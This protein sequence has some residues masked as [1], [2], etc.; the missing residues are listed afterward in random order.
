[1]IRYRRGDL[2]ADDSEAFV[3]AVNC[4]GVM[5]GGIARQF[6]TR[7]P[8][9]TEAYARACAQGEIRLGRVFVFQRAEGSH[10]RFIVSFPTMQGPGQ[11]CRV[12]DIESGLADLRASI[13]GHAMRSIAV[14][15]LGCGVGGLA[16]KDVRP[17]IA[18]ALEPV[19]DCEVSVYEPL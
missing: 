15:A 14:P 6:M 8:D 13:R 10:P 5:G 19:A 12:G 1:M 4:E 11:R 9:N 7:F 3:N 18:A 17:L 2:F 16:W